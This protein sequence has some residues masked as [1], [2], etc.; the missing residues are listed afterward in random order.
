MRYLSESGSRIMCHSGY[1]CA[2]PARLAAPV[3]SLRPSQRGDVGRALVIVSSAYGSQG[4]VAPLL[5]LA[6]E[7]AAARPRVLASRS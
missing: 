1:A 2:L 7:A 3:S 5:A 6:G 4:D